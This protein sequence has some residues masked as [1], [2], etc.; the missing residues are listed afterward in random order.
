M[1]NRR[2]LPFIIIG[3]VAA[4]ILLSAANRIFYRIEASQRAV[5][6]RSLSG[7]LEK[8]DIIRPGWTVIAPWN[9]LYVY[10]VSEDKIEETMDVLD[11][12]GLNISVD[13]TV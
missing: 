12:N 4:I 9:E 2:Y 10:D 6:F 1:D 13:V 11:K 7:K 5:L 3:L 8:D